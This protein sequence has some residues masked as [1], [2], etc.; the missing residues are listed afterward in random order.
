MTANE[1]IKYMISIWGE[2]CIFDLIE[3]GYEPVEVT[4]PTTGT[5]EWKLLLTQT[6]TSATLAPSRPTVS[7]VSVGNG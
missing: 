5:S 3:R 6:E 2:D 4:N 1:Y 7:P